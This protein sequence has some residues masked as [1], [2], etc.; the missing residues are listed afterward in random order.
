MKKQNSDLANCCC[1][2]GASHVAADNVLCCFQTKSG[3]PL[4]CHRAVRWWE[5][6][7]IYITGPTVWC[8]AVYSVS[9]PIQGW[10]WSLLRNWLPQH[11]MG[12]ISPKVVTLEHS[13]KRD[14]LHSNERENLRFH[15]ITWF[16]LNAALQCSAFLNLPLWEHKPEISGR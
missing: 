16:G 2:T 4:K 11:D 7:L 1:Y 12:C 14:R 5:C 13:Q 8:Q 9:P 15:R 6:P 3:D 10:R